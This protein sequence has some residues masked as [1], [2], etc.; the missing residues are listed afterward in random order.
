M[1]KI[2]RILVLFI[3]A[4]GSVAIGAE[5]AVESA[6]AWQPVLSSIIEMVVEVLTPILVAL[7]SYAAWKIAGKAGVEKNIA[8]D[9]ALKGYIKEGI[10]WAEQWG[11]EQTKKMG[12]KPTSDQKYAIAVKHILDLVKKSPLPTIAEDRLKA[13]IESKLAEK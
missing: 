4:I 9:E 11:V 3:F 10:E 13:L 2:F 6:N 8:A 1:S 7:A 5:A 12:T